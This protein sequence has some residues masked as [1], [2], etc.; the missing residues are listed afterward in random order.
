MPLNL[1]ADKWLLLDATADETD[2]PV[3]GVRFTFR[4]EP[5]GLRGSVVKWVTDEEIPLAD[6]RFDGSSLELQMTPD[7][8]YKGEIPTLKMT[9]R[10]DQSE[11]GWTN[12][13]FPPAWKLKLV[14][15]PGARI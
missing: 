14:R 5:D 6:L 13:D 7:E 12:Q 10:G 8:H 11:G 4:N 1:A 3:H 15:L 9:L 2:T